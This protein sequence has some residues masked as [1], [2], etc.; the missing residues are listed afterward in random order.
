MF[1]VELPVRMNI[2]PRNL[3][4]SWHEELRRNELG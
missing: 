2:R 1:I 3:G 4:V